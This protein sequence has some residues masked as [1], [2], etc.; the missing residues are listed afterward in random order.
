MKQKTIQF[1]FAGLFLLAASA[2]SAQNVD[3]NALSSLPDY[4]PD[5]F[6]GSGILHNIDLS[7]N[8]LIINATQYHYMTNVKVHSLNT[9]HSS[10]RTLKAGMGLGYNISTINDK[11]LIS[12]IWVLPEKAVILR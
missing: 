7:Q 9:E 8:V 1:L 5:S 11:Q 6:Y 12:E 4:Y 2:T 10:L 3:S